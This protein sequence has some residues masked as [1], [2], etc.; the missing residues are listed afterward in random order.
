MSER[1]WAIFND[2]ALGHVVK[3]LRICLIDSS[4]EPR[5]PGPV[6]CSDRRGMNVLGRVDQLVIAIID[7]VDIDCIVMGSYSQELTVG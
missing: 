4:E 3:L 5:I 6:H 2:G 7:G 1:R